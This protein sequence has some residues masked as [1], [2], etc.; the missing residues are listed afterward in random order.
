[1]MKNFRLLLCVVLC[2]S[3]ASSSPILEA[4]LNPSPTADKLVEDSEPGSIN[5]LLK[6]KLLCLTPGCIKAGKLPL[7]IHSITFVSSS[8]SSSS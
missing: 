7:A 6:D 8:L 4:G 2:S 1:M 5:S 3:F